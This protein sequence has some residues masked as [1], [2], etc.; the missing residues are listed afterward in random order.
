MLSVVAQAFD[1]Y[2]YFNFMCVCVCM[3]NVCMYLWK[4]TITKGLVV[5]VY[6]S[7]ARMNDDLNVT[8][9]TNDYCMDW[10]YSAVSRLYLECV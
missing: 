3:Y 4:G 9:N 10:V 5:Q 8:L 7:K 1:L 2:I 6:G